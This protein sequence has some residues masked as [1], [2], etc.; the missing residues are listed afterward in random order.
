MRL[1]RQK[2]GLYGVFLLMFFWDIIDY[3]IP[4]L[5]YAILVLLVVLCTDIKKNKLN[6]SFMLVM[7]LIILQGLINILIG[8]ESIGLL[9]KQVFAITICFIAYDNLLTPFSPGEIMSV[10][11]K[12]AFYMALI[13]VFEAALSLF[14]DPALAKFPI[15]FTYTTYGGVVGPFPRLAS[16]CHEPSFLGYFLAPAVCLYLGKKITPELIDDSLTVLNKEWEGIVILIAYIMTFSSVAYFGLAIMLLI[17]WWEKGFSIK[18]VVIPIIVIVVYMLIYNG[19]EDF[20]VRINDTWNIFNGISQASTVNL[21]SFTYYSNWNVACSAFIHTK[22]FG[23][24]IGSYQNMFDRFNIGNWGLSGLNLNR[25]DGNSAF[26][27]ILTELGVLGLLAVI[28]FLVRN[29]RC[30]RDKHTIY[31]C[32]IL[33][34]FLMFL[35]RQGNYTHAGSIMFVCLYLKVKKVPQVQCSEE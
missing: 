32:A 8:N 24:G 29:F 35:L 27:R 23:S 34:L 17:L 15:V 6:K 21:S 28:Y 20:R 5:T 11:W 18:K 10:Y 4:N 9:F 14:N 16:L 22:G 2:V 3:S 31:S 19:V 33:T 12:T 26:F 7:T 25:E 13:G 30:Q 1:N